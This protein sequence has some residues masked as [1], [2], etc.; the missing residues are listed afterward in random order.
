MPRCA[1]PRRG[2]VR[3]Y[4]P[5]VGISSAR[6]LQLAVLELPFAAKQS[7]APRPH[8]RLDDWIP[9]CWYIRLTLQLHQPAMLPGLQDDTDE[10]IAL[11]DVL[12]ACMAE[13][14][15]PPPDAGRD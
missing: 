3:Q 15:V 11:E 4:C 6:R 12:P 7:Q 9:N 1:A 14:V 10:L 13:F 5:R 8:Q 2:A